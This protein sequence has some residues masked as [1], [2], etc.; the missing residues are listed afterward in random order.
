VLRHVRDACTRLDM[1]LLEE[2]KSEPLAWATDTLRRET[3]ASPL[4]TP[5]GAQE[6][7]DVSM[8]RATDRGNRCLAQRLVCGSRSAARASLA[9]KVMLAR[10]HAERGYAREL[11]ARRGLA[12]SSE[13]LLQMRHSCASNAGRYGEGIAS[14]GSKAAAKRRRSRGNWQKCQAARPI[15]SSPC[16]CRLD[17]DDC[18]AERQ[19]P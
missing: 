18:Q 6:G 17:D 3:E 5:G 13:Q 19:G 16:S 2:Q 15:V 10:A 12:E 1:R 14:T 8:M 9:Q 4:Q 11:T 7:S